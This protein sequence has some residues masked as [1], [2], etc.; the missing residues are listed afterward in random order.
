MKVE[1][2]WVVYTMSMMAFV[3]WILLILFGGVGMFALPIDWI[4]EWRNRPRPRRSDEMRL[5]K[6]AL[7]R[8]AERLGKTCQE[9]MTEDEQ[10]TR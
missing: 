7:L 5:T 3:G 8:T 6:G 1:T 2:S 4:N 9:L 10:L